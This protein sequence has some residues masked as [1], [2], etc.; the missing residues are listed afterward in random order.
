MG[1]RDGAGASGKVGSWSIITN[2]RKGRKELWRRR[3]EK[4]GGEEEEKKKDSVCSHWSLSNNSNEIDSQH[5]C[6]LQLLSNCLTTIAACDRN[7][8]FSYMNSED[9]RKFAF[10]EFY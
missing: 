2:G 8:S 10:A 6:V 1:E 3:E 5:K 9:E 4:E 7:F